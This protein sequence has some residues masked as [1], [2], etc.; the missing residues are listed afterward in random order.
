MTVTYCFDLLF[1]PFK[2][3]SFHSD[4]GSEYINQYVARYVARLLKKLFIEFTK[5]RSRQTN[6][7]V[8]CEAR[9][10]ALGYNALAESVNAS[11]IRKTLSYQY[12]PQ[13]WAAELNTFNLN[14]LFP[15]INFHKPCFF[16]K[17]SL[18]KKASN[19]KFVRLKT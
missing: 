7:K 14:Y 2:I 4:N 16:Q 9:D 11:I 17:S 12:I 18:I 15:Y 3:I 8:N 6:E 13:K 19:E 5:L 10:S 1:F